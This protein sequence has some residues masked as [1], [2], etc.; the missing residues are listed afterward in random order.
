MA[1]ALDALRKMDFDAVKTT[2]VGL[3]KRIEGSY[4]ATKDGVI[5]NVKEQIGGALKQN[6]DRLGG[7]REAAS[8]NFQKLSTMHGETT[9]LVK[10]HSALLTGF[11]AK[12]LELRL[13]NPLLDSRAMLMSSMVD[14]L[15]GSLQALEEGQAELQEG[16]NRTLNKLEAIL[17]CSRVCES[18][19]N[20]GLRIGPR[21]SPLGQ[22]EERM[23]RF[24]FAWMTSCR[25]S[26]VLRRH[27]ILHATGCSGTSPCGRPSSAH[28]S[29][30]RSSG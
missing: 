9:S 16:Q 15:Y 5:A 26:G 28:T 6:L 29:P 4:A 17:N 8:E 13:K 18:I 12:M 14:E 23:Q 7:A 3:Q 20:Q 21:R 30:L 27:D 10:S 25:S 24:R 11:R 2:V 22:A 19:S 1:P